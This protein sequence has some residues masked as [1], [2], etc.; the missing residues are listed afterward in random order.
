MSLAQELGYVRQHH[1]DLPI[2]TLEQT[3]ECRLT[4]AGFESWEGMAA[5]G[6]TM[7]LLASAPGVFSR[8]LILPLAWSDLRMA[9]ATA[10]DITIACRSPDGQES[11]VTLIPGSNTREEDWVGLALSLLVRQAGAVPPGT[12]LPKTL[13]VLPPLAEAAEPLAEALSALAVQFPRFPRLGVWQGAVLLAIERPARAREVLERLEGLTE[14]ERPGWGRLLAMAAFLSGKAR[15]A[16]AL[17]DPLSVDPRTTVDPEN[18]PWFRLGLLATAMLE[19][20]PGEPCHGG[21]SRY[22]PGPPLPSPG[23]DLA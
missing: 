20:L 23:V 6:P 14:A 18:R 12:P 3:L 11:L 21:A 1:P 7:L 15:L 5:T 9:R 13:P 2:D 4:G 10:E 8:G 16:R 22:P 19:G 17:L